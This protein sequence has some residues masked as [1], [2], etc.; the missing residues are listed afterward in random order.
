MEFGHW[1][2]AL[3]WMQAG[4]LLIPKSPHQM[5]KITQICPRLPHLLRPDQCFL[6]SPQKRKD[7]LLERV[8]PTIGATGFEPA[9]PTTPK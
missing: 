1:G 4:I 7:P 6:R 8:L 9:T 5:P 2:H 3:S